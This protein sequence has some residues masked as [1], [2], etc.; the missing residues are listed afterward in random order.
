M[1][2]AAAVYRKSLV[3]HLRS[4]MEYPADFWIMASA[5]ALWQV[6]AFAFIT[7]LF[8][9]VP[10]VAGWGYHEM[11]VLT[12]FLNLSGAS[13]ALFW[14]GIWST[15]TMIV[16]GDMDYRITRPAPVIIQVASAHIGM[17]AFGELTMGA[18][19][20]IY[21]WIGAGLNPMLIPLALLLLAVAVVFQCSFLTVMCAIGFW[22][23]GHFPSFA[24]VAGDLQFEVMRFPLGIYPAAV[25]VLVTF[26]LPF[27]F[28]SF[29][30]VQIL[31]GERS[32]WWL[33]GPVAAAAAM[34]AIMLAVFH[35]GLRNYDS[36]G[37]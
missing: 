15:P 14:D 5:G 1:R 25:R 2:H 33:A 8:A 23:K 11:L 28:A 17:Q 30:P 35:A 19:M 36:S 26:V 20:L 9:N 10:S 37:H 21:G 4:T 18:A 12:G 13:T 22:V 29:I 16:K 6:L 7:V 31:I 24:W 27:A 32:A 3:A 34:V